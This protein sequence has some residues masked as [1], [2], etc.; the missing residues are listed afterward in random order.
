MKENLAVQYF[1]VDN[2]ISIITLAVTTAPN[3]LRVVKFVDAGM[4]SSRPTGI[5]LVEFVSL[6]SVRYAPGVIQGSN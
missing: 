4:T 2:T 3:S 1:H 6:G 5:A